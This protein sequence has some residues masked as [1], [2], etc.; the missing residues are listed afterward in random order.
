VLHKQT[1]FYSPLTFHHFPSSS[2]K[3]SIVLWPI[4]IYYRIIIIIIIIL[5]K[6]LKVCLPVNCWELGR[7]RRENREIGTTTEERGKGWKWKVENGKSVGSGTTTTNK[8][9]TNKKPKHHTMF[10][11][12]V[13]KIETWRGQKQCSAG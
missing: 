6:N 2:E 1:T 5:K 11:W 13:A 12:W 7:R 8:Q 9:T 10:V 3:P 4:Y